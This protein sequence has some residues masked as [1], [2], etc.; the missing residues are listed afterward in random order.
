[1][2][3]I[4]C[5]R[6]M[7]QMGTRKHLSLNGQQSSQGHQQSKTG[8]TGC[9]PVSGEILSRGKPANATNRHLTTYMLT[10]ELLCSRNC[11]ESAGARKGNGECL[12]WIRLL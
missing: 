1:M 7:E 11:L 2:E 4:Q 5:F 9:L 6:G 3:K 8:M 12:S 10:D